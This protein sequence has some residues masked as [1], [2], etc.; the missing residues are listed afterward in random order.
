MKNIFNLIRFTLG[1]LLLIVMI[2]FAVINS[3]DK[4]CKLSDISI[5]LDENKFVTKDV[6]IEYLRENTLH[7][8]SILLEDVSFRD[9]EN[10]LTQHPSIKSAEVYS[11]MNANVF[12]SVTQRNPIVSI[13]EDKKG[14]YLDED[15]LEIPLSNVYTSRML[16]V[17][18]EVNSVNNKD[19]FNLTHCIYYN[20]FWKKQIV[21]INIENS[22]LLMLTKLGE[23]LEFGEIKNVKEKFENL[24]LYY[25]KGNSQNIDY[26]S[27]NLEYKNQIVCIKK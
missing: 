9:I 16:L 10:V 4:Y 8:D 3:G 2:Y 15:G 1:V 12:F 22:K 20:D 14:Y 27:L 26:K 6:I 7:P 25:E 13:Q 21:Q 18:G 17:T 19:L 23:Q 11:D 24:M 5:E